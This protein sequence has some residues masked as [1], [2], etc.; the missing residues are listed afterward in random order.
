MFNEESLRS[1]IV[2]KWG[3][4]GAHV[5]VFDTILSKLKTYGNHLSICR[6]HFDHKVGNIPELCNCGWSEIEKTLK[7]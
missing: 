7:E 3:P 2:E 5:D 6:Y 1:D 4:A